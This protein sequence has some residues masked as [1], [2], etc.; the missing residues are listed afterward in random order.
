MYAYICGILVCFRSYLFVRAP[1][2]DAKG[3]DRGRSSGHCRRCLGAIRAVWSAWR[4]LKVFF[5]PEMDNTISR[6]FY[7]LHETLFCILCFSSWCFL[8]ICISLNSAQFVTTL[9]FPVHAPVWSILSSKFGR[10][11]WRVT[12]ITRACAARLVRYVFLKKKQVAGPHSLSATLSF[13]TRVQAPATVFFSFSPFVFLC[14]RVFCSY[15]THLFGTV[16]VTTTLPSLCRDSFG[17]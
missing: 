5:L 4:A 7:V 12:W 2:A 3:V 6:S 15:Y 11:S 9:E 17:T 8:V 13:R 14:V 10:A 16:R 1:F